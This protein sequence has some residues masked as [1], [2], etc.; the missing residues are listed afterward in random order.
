MLATTLNG[1]EAL[2]G[3]FVGGGLVGVL[4]GSGASEQAAI[5][6]AMAPAMSSKSVLVGTSLVI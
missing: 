1:S 2:T 6:I 4:V 3:V 5:A